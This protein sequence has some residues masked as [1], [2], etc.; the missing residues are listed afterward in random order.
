MKW[1]SGVNQCNK[2]KT[3]TQISCPH[4]LPSP[5]SSAN[6]LTDVDLQKLMKIF[7]VNDITNGRTKTQRTPKIHMG[8]S[9]GVDPKG[10][11]VTYC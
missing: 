9:Q 10:H 8:I 11:P 3:Y 4:S 2:M 5:T 1:L 6:A 7:Q